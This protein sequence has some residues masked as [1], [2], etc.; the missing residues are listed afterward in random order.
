MANRSLILKPFRR[1]EKS[2]LIIFIYVKHF[3][4]FNNYYYLIELN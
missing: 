3:I 4:K 1:N 2:Y